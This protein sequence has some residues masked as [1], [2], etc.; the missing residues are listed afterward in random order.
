MVKPPI[1]LHGKNKVKIWLRNDDE[2][3]LNSC[4]SMF[5][6]CLA[7]NIGPKKLNLSPIFIHNKA[8]HLLSEPGFDPHSTPQ[9]RDLSSNFAKQNS[10]P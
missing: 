4:C 8:G 7:R 3:C 9:F 6:L 5:K 2:K 10:T 1:P